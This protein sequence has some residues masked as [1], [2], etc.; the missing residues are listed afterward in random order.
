MIRERPTRKACFGAVLVAISALLAAV[1]AELDAADFTDAIVKVQMDSMAGGTGSLVHQQGDYGYV[2]TCRHVVSGAQGCR[3]TFR[4]GWYCRGRVLEISGNYDVAIIRC[5]PFG[6]VRAV[7]LPLARTN[8]P[9]GANVEIYGYGGQY[10]IDT[11]RVRLMRWRSALAYKRYGNGYLLSFRR[12]AMSGDSGGPVVHNGKLVGLVEAYTNYDAQG[13]Y[14]TPVYQLLQRC[15]PGYSCPPGYQHPRQPPGGREFVPPS[16]QQPPAPP[17]LPTPYQKPDVETQPSPK[18]MP[19][20]RADLRVYEQIRE[21]CKEIQKE[22]REMRKESKE[23]IEKSEKK[24]SEKI[25]RI[26][27]IIEKPSPEVLQLL[28]EIRDKLDS[29]QLIGP[30]GPP[31]PQG[32]QGPQG[33]P[34]PPAQVDLDGLAEQ[35][36]AQ[37]PP[38][39]I[40]LL[41]KSGKVI[42]EQSR[43]LGQ[44]LRIRFVPK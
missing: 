3:I 21:S 4:N 32:L 41:D 28:I 9:A 30:E 14:L 40:Q 20:P 15:I 26:E 39:R 31:G 19:S 42:Q 6:G 7:I 5:G 16:P 22:L 38:V 12:L 34:G 33:D 18:P 25:E 29:G 11:R 2:V 43:P 13:A 44:P 17:T 27:K 8:P 23:R 37:L 10:G 24:E 36:I 1:G 35:L